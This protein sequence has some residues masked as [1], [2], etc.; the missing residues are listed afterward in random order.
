KGVLFQDVFPVFQDPTAVEAL[1]T[2]FVHHIN[3]TH[4][5]KI[6]VIVGACDAETWLE[7][8]GF[9]FGPIIA[10]RIGAAF[11][12]LEPG[13]ASPRIRPFLTLPVAA[14]AAAIELVRKSG[15]E[16][17]KCAFVVELPFL[18]GIKALGDVPAYSMIRFD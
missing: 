13:S 10:M 15:A 1:I 9:L 14:A 5:G 7:S 4:A 16:V 12:P 3:S 8:R 6:D 11:V 2:H 18:K 17:V